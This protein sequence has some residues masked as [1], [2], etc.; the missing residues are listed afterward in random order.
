M[1]TQ[2][3]FILSESPFWPQFTLSGI[4]FGAKRVMV[5]NESFRA[6][7]TKYRGSGAT[8]K[9]AEMLKFPRKEAGRKETETEGEEK[10]G[11]DRKGRD[12]R[13]RHRMGP[14]IGTEG[15]IV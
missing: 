1:A 15:E 11:R 9:V 7:K 14:H 5:S 12:R 2:S 4:S 6:Q 3:T 13:K 10:E 8:L